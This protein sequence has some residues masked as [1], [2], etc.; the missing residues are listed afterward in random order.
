MLARLQA[1]VANNLFACLL[2]SKV[3]DHL[4]LTV[5]EVEELQT[6]IRA[7]KEQLATRADKLKEANTRN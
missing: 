6:Q 2:P 7:A 4:E 3:L 5:E 1:L